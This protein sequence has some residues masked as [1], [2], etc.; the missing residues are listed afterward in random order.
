MH[1]LRAKRIAHNESQARNRNEQRS[2]GPDDPDAVLG[3]VC[4]CGDAACEAELTMTCRDYETLRVHP[5]RFAVLPGHEIADA[6]T[7]VEREQ[8]YLVVEK[9]GAAR[10]IAE[11]R[12]PRRHLKTCRVLV[13]DDVVEVRILIKM[14]L[15]LEASTTVV[16]E[17]G[18][19]V[20]AIAAA[21]EAQPDV[22][23][24]DVQM[25]V[26]D[27][28][29]ALPQILA[30]APRA[31]VIIFSGIDEGDLPDR[32]AYQVVPKGG[33]PSV[34]VDAVRAVAAANAV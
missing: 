17:A 26:M 25:P 21:A 5:A 34:L 8:G 9:V 1:D 12:D 10:E 15:Q 30:A 29:T 18:T 24:L 20:E 28:L 33:D 16:A 31:K 7:V 14:L 32:G 4:E 3:V 23:I 2:D 6:E 27:G 22:V 13:V 19:G 11:S